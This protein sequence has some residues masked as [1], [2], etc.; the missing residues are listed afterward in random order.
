MSEN[1]IYDNKYNIHYLK[2]VIHEL[3]EKYI[4]ENNTYSL[5]R[6]EHHIN[7]LKNL[8]DNENKKN[9]ERITKFNE[10]ATEQDIF[11]KL[12][13]S[14][15]NFYYM[16]YNNKY[17][18][19]DGN[20]YYIIG[21]DIILHKLLTSITNNQILFQW[22][23]KTKINIL[24]QIKNISLFSSIP[25]IQTIQNILSFLTLFFISEEESIYFLCVLGDCILKKNNNLLY[26]IRPNTKN[27]ISAID[28]IIYTTLGYS[29]SNNFIV[30]YHNSHDINNYRLIKTK[31]T[32]S[33]ELVKNTIND[34][35][36]ELMCVST[37]YSDFY[38][39]SEK[40][41][42][43]LDESISNY[44]LF[45]SVNTT[46]QII[47]KFISEYIEIEDNTITWKNMH[48]IWKVY[49]QDMKIPTFL[50]TNVLQ[51]LLLSKLNH[52]IN[53]CKNDIYF[54]NITSKYLPNV[55]SFLSFWNEN[56]TIYSNDNP[57]NDNPSND[58][59][60]NDNPSNNNTIIDDSIDTEC[61]YIYDYEINEIL[62]LYKNSGYKTGNLNCTNISSLINHYFS[63]KVEIINDKYIKNIKCKLWDKG[64]EIDTFLNSYKYNLLKS[65]S[66]N[67]N[68]FIPIDKLYT[69]Y[70]SECS[71]KI[72]II[73]YDYFQ[74]YV[75]LKLQI[76]IRS[77]NLIDNKWI[78]T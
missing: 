73:S 63:P 12:F 30:K 7:G 6:L 66:C 74:K 72:F 52:E 40:Y 54:K 57:S 28:Y 67:I 8:I 32:S 34:I 39:N 10:L 17:Y 9:N 69:S 15:N 11:S 33:T 53:T 20:K 56:I 35:G 50:Y 37:Y 71:N 68:D 24:K 18:E 29:I 49:L 45:F 41:I 55:S 48:Y 23:H 36:L 70:K 2:N 1:N 3:Y 47:D 21:E 58:N 13:L 38:E 61:N 14:Q 75:Y 46:N 42:L 16:S 43:K 22:K 5:S 27:L 19:Y 44:I 65:Y 64:I 62:Q 60:S 76:Y 59:P 31:T 25:K 51:E 26:F 4:E 77:D 78:E